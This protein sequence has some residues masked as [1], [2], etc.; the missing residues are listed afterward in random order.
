MRKQ[1]F[2]K[3]MKILIL[4]MIFKLNL[5]IFLIYFIYFYMNKIGFFINNTS[6]K[7]KVHINY[8][9]F[10]TLYDHFDYVYVCDTN[11]KYS[12][13]LKNKL[14]KLNNIKCYELNS[15][16]NFFNKINYLLSNININD[17]NICVTIITDDYIYLNKLDKYFT[18][19]KETNYD[20]I[21]F[22]DSTEIF[23]HLQF[24]ILS[25]KYNVLNS[26][27]ELISKYNTSIKPFELL[28]IDFLKDLVN[29]S[30]NKSIYIK[31]AYLDSIFKKNI[32]L[33][34][35]EHYNYLLKNN[36]LPIISIE[37][38]NQFREKYDKQDFVFKELPPDFD[39]NIYK[40]YDDL[41]TFDNDFIKNHFLNHGQFE[42]RRFKKK[43]I[44]LSELIYNV[45]NKIKLVKY[46]DFPLDFDFHLYKKFNKDLKDLNKLELKNHWL[47]YGVFE[48]RKYC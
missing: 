11:D 25:L 4:V 18:Y 22:T 17:K 14:S 43:E 12:L 38:L 34:N 48:N 7:K 45:L 24:S 30:N 20:V 32:F 13:E 5:F 6:D 27:K 9:N 2:L 8:H 31:V 33:I 47:N 3:I 23:Y 21:S 26:F 29:L 39:Y 37:L 16:F 10:T 35:N 42:C 41:K 40:S 36:I 28:Y 46:F 44:I 15:N 19:I 1:I